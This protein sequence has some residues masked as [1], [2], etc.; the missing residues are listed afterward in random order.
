MKRKTISILL[1]AIV[2][3]S[4]AII[5][6]AHPSSWAKEEINKAI[7][8]NLVPN[9]LQKEY[10]SPITR[11]EFCALAVELYER[12]SG[13][14]IIERKNFIDSE[15]I[16]VRKIGGLNIIKGVGGGKF[17][18]EGLLTR[19][20]AAVIISNLSESIGY[21]LENGDHVF[22]DEKDIS[23]WAIKEV[24]DVKASNIMQGVND[25]NFKPKSNYTKEESIVT[26]L[27]LYNFL[28]AKMLTEESV[29]NSIISLKEKY[30][31]GTPWTND[32]Y[33]EW[34][35]GIYGGGYGC[36]AFAF[37]ASDK[38]FG[39]L[40]ARFH[41][42]INKIKVGDIV[43]IN[44]DTHSVIVLSINDGIYE[45]A[46]GNYGGKI[47]WGRKFSKNE[48]KERMSYVITRYP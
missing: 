1:I 31:D 22:K 36:A 41:E 29:Y 3:L 38:A 6:Y 14:E 30:P 17:N 18:P 34:N 42:D 43:R 46:E 27:R 39:I 28:K 26:I 5:V 13:E 15:D 44:N 33:Y 8:L 19:E 16:N 20:Q 35:G 23:S 21:P 7:D 9:K 12:I 45:I 24:K 48:L 4:N 37:M 32:N 11:A 40:P 10:S 25:N 2:V 47:H